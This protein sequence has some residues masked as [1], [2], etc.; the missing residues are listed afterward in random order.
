MQSVKLSASKVKEY[1]EALLAAQGG[2]CVLCGEVI[3]DGEDVLDHDHKSGHVRAVLHRGCN[4]MLGHI[5]NNRARNHLTGARLWRWLANVQAYLMAQYADKPLHHT[6][7]T[8][9]QKVE[10]TKKLAK[11][12]RQRRKAIDAS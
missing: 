12:S 6:H 11:A 10:R 5:E 2:R 1:R 8:V 7:R 4:A 3:A 9:E